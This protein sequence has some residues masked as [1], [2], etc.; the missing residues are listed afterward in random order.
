M[1]CNLNLQNSVIEVQQK[2]GIE[3]ESIKVPRTSS[4]KLIHEAPHDIFV[5]FVAHFPFLH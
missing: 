1:K 4:R 2:L 5:F 3:N